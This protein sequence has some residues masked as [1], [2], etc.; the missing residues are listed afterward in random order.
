[1]DRIKEK[2]GNW[3]LVT[4]A[5]S[6]IGKCFAEKLAAKGFNLVLVARNG[7]KLQSVSGHLSDKYPVKIH[8]IMADLSEESSVQEIIH[9]T[10]EIPIGLLINNAGYSLT[11][12]FINDDI[13]SQ[14]KLMK[15]NS[16][17][18]MQLCYH[19]GKQM[20]M[21]KNGGI[22]NVSTVSALMP[23]PFWTVYSA[24]KSFLKS[25]SESLWYE[26]KPH[27]VDVLA[28]CPGAVKTEF[29]RTAQVRQTGLTVHAVVNAGLYYLGKKPSVIVGMNNKQISGI[30]G[31]LPLKTKIKMGAKAV[32]RMS[33]KEGI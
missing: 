8:V 20:A 14:T 22:I 10:S 3:A 28:L 30:M 27:G 19:F 1:M 11:G 29:Y 2:Y 7:E 9:K 23:L 13:E 26:L 25:F 33:Q 5:S 21:N 17:V 18:P 12:N 16:L 31:L 6:G 24:S 32:R 15:I 4:G